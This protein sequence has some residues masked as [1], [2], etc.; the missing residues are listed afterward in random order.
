M[1]AIIIGAGMGGL[2][3][4]IALRRIGWDVEVYEQVVENKPVGAAISLWSNGVK[5]LNYL[6]LEKQI[7]ALG[8]QMETMAY[9]DGFTGETMTEFSLRPVV[10]QTGQRPYPVSRAELQSMLMNEFGLEH[11]HLGKRMVDIADDGDAVTATFADGSTATGDILIG[12]DGAKSRTRDYVLDEPVERRYAGY[13]NFN[14]LVDIDETI[15]P[16]TQWTTYVGDGKRVSVMPIAGNRFYFFFDV[17]LPAG[18]DYDRSQA[19]DVLSEHFSGWAPQV[20]KLIGMLDPL[21]VNRVEIFDIDPFDTWVKG[22]V[23]LLGDAGHN[24]TPDIGQ[25]GCSAMEDAVVLAIA[26][27]TNTLGVED[28]LIR[29]RNRRTARAGDLVL[30]ARKRCDVTHAKDPEVTQAWYDELRTEDGT[31]IIRGIVSNI[32]GNPL[33]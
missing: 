19:K 22:R 33:G 20:H 28:A 8:G 16:A 6:G 17:P 4:G 3:A 25:G 1:K 30:R 24:T 23:A 29:Y 31:G 21:A 12:A 5:C 7:A 14:G 2:S 13:V 15:A 27:Q 26:L 18:L 9:R 10:E 32:V 11:I